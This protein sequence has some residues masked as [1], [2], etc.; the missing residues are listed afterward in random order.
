MIKTGILF[1]SPIIGIPP[2]LRETFSPFIRRGFPVEFV[3]IFERPKEKSFWKVLGLTALPGAHARRVAFANAYNEVHMFSRMYDAIRRLQD[4][5]CDKIILGGMSGGFI[6]SSR[7]AQVPL[8]NELDY[9]TWSAIQPLITGVF[10][11]SPLLFYPIGVECLGSRPDR[12]PSHTP[13]VLVWG[14]DDDIVPSSTM[15][16]GQS[17]VQ[18]YPH[19]IMKILRKSDFPE[20][21]AMRHQFFGGK[22]FVGFLPN[23]FWHP[24]AEQV[25][26]QFICDNIPTLDIKAESND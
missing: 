7:I 23:S 26:L 2:S 5:G 10:G 19:I 14:E 21:K 4:R 15:V 8:D 11:I 9:N 25:A 18:A 3:D 12:I 24:Q 16:Y 13:V 22:D 20:Q 1:V 17:L 6:F